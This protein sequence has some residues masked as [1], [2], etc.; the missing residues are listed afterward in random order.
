[1]K[2]F[3]YAG[4]GYYFV[5]ICALGRKK[6]FGE[7]VGARRDAPINDNKTMPINRD[8]TN[9]VLNEN[10]KSISNI[11]GTLPEHHPVMLDEIC[12]MPNHIHLILIIKNKKQGAGENAEQGASRRAPTGK[13]LGWIIGMFKTECTKTINRLNGTSGKQIFQR[14]YYERIIRNEEEYFKIKNYIRMN[15][16]M[17]ERDRNNPQNRI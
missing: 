13:T 12:I 16:L 15:P 1:M 14:N 5:T 3:D 9:M 10:G 17:W 7:I 8:K 6:M 4:G 11:W 2:G